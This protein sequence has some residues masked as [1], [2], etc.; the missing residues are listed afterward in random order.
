MQPA[1]TVEQPSAAQVITELLVLMNRNDRTWI[2]LFAENA[3]FESL[4]AP[5]TLELERL[6]GTAIYNLFKTALVQMP[7]RFSN[8]RIYPTTN[9]NLAWAEFHGE[10]VVVATGRPYHQ[11]YVLRLETRESR[12]THYREYSNPMS[13][14]EA[15][16]G[17]QN[18]QQAF[19]HNA[20]NAA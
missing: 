8:I 15:W 18:F 17:L 13:A 5:P 4:Y 12:I 9:P 11:D 20:E 6:E 14:I 16:G 2:D 7:L 10:A 1:P 19:P 3:V